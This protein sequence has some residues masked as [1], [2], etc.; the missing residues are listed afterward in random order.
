MSR[1]L[2]VGCDSLGAKH[3]ILRAKFGVDEVI[4]WDGRKA[5]PPSYLP[6][7]TKAVLIFTG[8]VNHA[9]MHVVRELA[10]KQG[11]KTLFL[12]RGLAELEC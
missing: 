7:G 10:K 2:V 6:K 5:K 9:T 4:H 11:V 12:R 1:C 3:E 8:F